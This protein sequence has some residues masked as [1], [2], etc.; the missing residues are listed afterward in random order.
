MKKI[1]LLSVFL[2]V[3]VIQPLFASDF[4]PALDINGDL[5]YPTILTN[6]SA[7]LEKQLGANIG[8]AGS[9]MANTDL[10]PQLWFIPT[11]TFNYSSTAQPLNVDDQRFMF[12]QWMDIYLSGGFNYQLN[13]DWELRARALF[14]KDYAQ[15]TADEKLG[16]GLYDYIDQ[17]FYAENSSKFDIGGQIETVAGFK[18][19]DRR[20]P[21]YQALLSGANPDAVGGTL[22][23]M[24]KDVKDCLTY[25]FYL[26]NEIKLGNSGW[27]PSINFDY[28]YM[29]YFDQKIVQPDGSLSGAR[30]ID[31]FATLDIDMPYF[32]DK[33]SGASLG[34]KLTAKITSQNYYDTL[35]DLDPGNDVYT[36]D[37]YSY[38]E[39]TVKLSLTYELQPEFINK[40]KPV[41]VIGVI[42]DT[43]QYTDRDAKDS[44]GQYTASKQYENYYTLS[45]DLKQK[46][47]DFWSCYANLTYNRYFSNM[48]WDAYGTLNYTYMTVALGTVLSF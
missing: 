18:Y 47:T 38:L 31:R 12:S 13:D 11:F 4:V 28:D 35:G 22:N 27:V 40:F 37:Y 16:K 17:G 45:L 9:F 36:Y 5:T 29:P 39:H 25:S 24:E 44:T 3:L 15:Q 10:M 34:Y 6:E 43:I 7:Q 23:A 42:F 48:K 1:A 14:R 21:N 33:V 19:I 30:R 2:L 26:N 8:A 32:A 46:I 20:F 41:L